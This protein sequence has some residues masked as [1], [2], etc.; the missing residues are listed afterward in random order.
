[1][2]VTRTTR[3]AAR[4]RSRRGCAATSAPDPGGRARRVHLVAEHPLDPPAR[5][6]RHDDALD[7]RP[8]VVEQPVAEQHELDVVAVGERPR[9][10]AGVHLHPAG[11]ARREEGRG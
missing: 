5:V 3:P 10:L 11:L 8:A 2:V 7:V 6:D 9:Q 4:A 1:M